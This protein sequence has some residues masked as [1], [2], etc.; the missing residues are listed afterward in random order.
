MSLFNDFFQAI[1]GHLIVSCQ[2]STGD[3]FRDSP[4]IGRFA[5][6]AVDGGARGI[7]A[8][9]PAD[10]RAIRAVVDV[11]IIGI[12]K[13]YMQD[14]RIL[15]TPTFEDARALV[16]AGA[17]AIAIDCSVRGQRYGA[18]EVVKRIREELGVPIMAD[19]STVEEAVA[20][21]AA[22]VDMAGSTLRG[23]TDD[24]RD[25]DVFQPWFITALTERL[26]IPV[27][28][29]GRVNTPREAAAALDAGAWAV[30][31]GTA[32][33][34]PHD[35]TRWFVE[36]LR[37][38]PQCV[39]AIDMGG[40][41]TKSGI[42]TAKAELLEE[43]STPTPFSAGRAALLDHLKRITALTLD[44]AR[45]IGRKPERAGIATAGWVDPR[46]GRVVY[47]TENLPGWTGAEIAREVEE[48][49]GLPV[50]VENDANALAVGEHHFGAA[51]GVDHFLCVTLGTGIGGGCYVG[52][53]LNHGTHCF[54]NALGHM[55]VVPDGK[56]CN[57]GLKGCLEV[58]AS[59][60]A[61]RSYAGSGYDS[62]KSVI[63]AANCGIGSAREAVRTL[64]RYL[65]M[66]AASAVQLL[67]PELI[68]LS[69]GLVQSNPL[70]LEEFER[71]LLRRVTVPAERGLR[72]VAS[73]LGYHAG[74]L[75]AAAVAMETVR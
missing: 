25:V 23:Y 12:Q 11:P 68:I 66:G 31:V 51:R 38:G 43:R 49:C 55:P 62:A 16:E 27:I 53:R 34:R 7:R 5:R 74:A 18:F 28:A 42:V 33:T 41:N 19:I 10:I 2:A 9:S 1:H 57:C 17:T 60:E 35:I 3:A 52:G 65:A 15:I 72:V 50:A 6:A 20:A 22:G 30:I 24:T 67:D 8:D 47:A 71:E 70:L 73:S 26:R 61:L 21:E 44:D 14:G 58:Y 75:G 37:P 63:E 46:T 59:A 13:R 4:S 40:T 54:A 69:G 48:S 29:E 39:V 45:R 36:A 64:A 56:P 32:I